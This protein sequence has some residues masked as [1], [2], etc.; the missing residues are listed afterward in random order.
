M[1]QHD[2]NI[3]DQPGGSFLSDLN[4]ALAAIVSQNSGASA[5]SPTYA[6]QFWADTTSGKL[7]MRNAANTAWLDVMTLADA[8]ALAAASA[9]SATNA[10]N[11]TGTSP[12]NIPTSAL[13]SGTANSTTF[14]RGDRTWVPVPNAG[15][16]G[17]FRNLIV[18][19][20]AATPDS[21][22]DILADEV[23]LEDT[24]GNAKRVESVSLTADIT[25]TGANGLDTGAEAANKWYSIW[26]IDN[27][28]TT[29]S[30]LSESATAPTLP[31]GY[32]FKARVGWVRNDG[33][34]NF[35]RFKQVN[36]RV[37][38][39]VP[40]VM[41]SGVAGD[42]SIPTWV[43]VAV[44]VFVPPTAG[45]IYVGLQRNGSSGPVMVAPN[46]GFGAI[47]SS[48][49]SQPP[50]ND[51]DATSTTSRQIQGSFV[52]ESANIYWASSG[53]TNYLMCQGWDDV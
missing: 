28:T 46:N 37:Q 24:S 50:L 22:V 49:S 31:S 42:V 30:L 33:S 47:N 3:A 20:N 6:Y 12:S 40:Q 29:A 32:T 21:K 10:T 39:I 14:L 18:Q 16:T 15:I 35:I 26:V 45:V 13:G 53:A 38:Y 44:G 11:L 25:V 9:D 1:A 48:G 52:L 41:A 43:A 5:P 34:S 23:M 17:S 51:N 19:T 36:R 2:Y 27:G 4:A 7:K 8:K